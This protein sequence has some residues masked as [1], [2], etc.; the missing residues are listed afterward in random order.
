MPRPRLRLATPPQPA[1]LLNGP[2]GPAGGAAG[3]ARATAGLMMLWR[4]E[5]RGATRG[6][7]RR[8][9]P[10]DA[11]R[12]QVAVAGPR[13]PAGPTTSMGG[14]G[15]LGLQGWD[16]GREATRNGYSGER[17]LQ[18]WDQGRVAMGPRAAMGPS[19][20]PSWKWKGHDPLCCTAACPRGRPGSGVKGPASTRCAPVPV[21]PQLPP[22]LLS[23]VTQLPPTLPP[24]LPPSLLSQVTCC[25]NNSNR[26]EVVSRS[27]RRRGGGGGVADWL[28]GGAASACIAT[29]AGSAK[30]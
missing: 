19:W 15:G 27:C 24:S 20:L 23:Q 11:G 25:K 10:A 21:Q 26:C 1:M 22:S 18:R 14:L 9:A 2:W 8:P 4:R 13:S 6:C 16:G 5:E 17:Q 28:A 12:L 30:P 3:R 29:T 7:R